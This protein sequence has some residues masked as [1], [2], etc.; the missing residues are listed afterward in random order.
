MKWVFHTTHLLLAI[1]TAKDTTLQPQPIRQLNP[2]KGIAVVGVVQ[3]L[4]GSQS[5]ALTE[6]RN[7]ANTWEQALRHGFIPRLLAWMA[8]RR[9]ILLSL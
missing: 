8:L 4:S 5:P 6:L 9:V 3:M 2:H 1:L 7:K